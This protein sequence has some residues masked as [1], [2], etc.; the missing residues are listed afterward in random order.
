MIFYVSHTLILHITYQLMLQMY[1]NCFLLF[2]ILCCAMILLSSL[3]CY[4]CL[5]FFVCTGCPVLTYFMSNCPMTGT[6]FFT[7]ICL[8]DGCQSV[9]TWCHS[10]KRRVYKWPSQIKSSII[11]A[12]LR[13]SAITD[14]AHPATRIRRRASG[15]TH[16][17]TQQ[18]TV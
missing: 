12:L 7:C 14:C 2:S 5:L 3:V 9:K 11:N 10:V 18:L 4:S 8:I 6:G 16:P 17:V 15:D 1:H 13:Q